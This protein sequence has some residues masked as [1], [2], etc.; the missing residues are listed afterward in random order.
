M[1]DAYD[2]IVKPGARPEADRRWIETPDQEAV[3]ITHQKAARPVVEVCLL[4]VCEGEV[5]FCSLCVV[6]Y[7]ILF[8]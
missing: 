8:V 2:S 5:Q 1:T 7:T 6:G 4:L 3:V